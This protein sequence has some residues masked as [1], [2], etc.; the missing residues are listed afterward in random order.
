MK[1]NKKNNG[2]YIFGQVVFFRK[3]LII[4][5]VNAQRWT[6]TN[7]NQSPE[8][9]EWPKYRHLKEKSQ[10]FQNESKSCNKQE[11]RLNLH[12]YK[13]VKKLQNMHAIISRAFYKLQYS[14]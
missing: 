13:S 14:I 1:S 6:K 7:C 3:M 12:V 9:F 11:K 8:L 2:T 10:N 4:S 5:T